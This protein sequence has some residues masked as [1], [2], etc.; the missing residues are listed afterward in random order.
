MLDDYS[1]YA[2]SKIVHSRG[3]TKDVINFLQECIDKLGK[4]VKILTDHGSQFGKVFSKW[5]KRN[6]I[7]HSKATV[8]HPQTLGKVESL[9]KTLGR[10]FILDFCSIGDG[11]AKLNC[12]M[13][14]YNHIKYHS[15]IECTPAE[16]YGFRRDKV[17]VLS[18]IA[19][20][21]GLVKLKEGLN[22]V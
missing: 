3:T 7:K 6:K 17:K 20:E 1:R 14:W 13:K 5:C 22:K 2:T 15:V 21:F 8:R 10:C 11:Q 18:E 12:F 9:N 19:E 4:P 16:A